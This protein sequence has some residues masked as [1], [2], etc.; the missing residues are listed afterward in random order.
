MHISEFQ[1]SILSL[2]K[3]HYLRGKRFLSALSAKDVLLM[4]NDTGNFHKALRVGKL[5]QTNKSFNPFSMSSIAQPIFNSQK[6]TRRARSA[7]KQPWRIRR[8]KA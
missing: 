1:P 7:I 5:Q 4:P 3:F 2:F 6:I 8:T